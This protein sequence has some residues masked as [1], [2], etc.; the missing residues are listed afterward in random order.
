MVPAV[1]L[2]PSTLLTPYFKNLRPLEHLPLKPTGMF[3][4]PGTNTWWILDQQ[5]AVY[6]VEN[7][8]NTRSRVTIMNIQ[9]R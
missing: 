4:Q 9:G 5:G 7:D 6:A 2:T 3:M 8:P 1:Q